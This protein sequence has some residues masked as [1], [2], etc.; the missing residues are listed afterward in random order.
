MDWSGAWGSAGGRY[1][2]RGGVREGGMGT[3]HKELPRPRSF[4]FDCDL[5]TRAVLC[6]VECV[7]LYD[8]SCVAVSNQIRLFF[9]A[10]CAVSVV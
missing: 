10:L 3:P 2:A 9:G 7:A 1:E 4:G 8:A 6:S 5:A